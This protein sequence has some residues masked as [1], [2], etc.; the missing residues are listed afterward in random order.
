MISASGLS[1]Y[2]IHSEIGILFLPYHH[3]IP[4][5]AVE[6][7]KFALAIPILKNQTATDINV[8]GTAI[9]ARL[10]GATYIVRQSIQRYSHHL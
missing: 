5:I 1:P 6:H 10:Q 4:Q 8:T 2:I 9:P 3:K 7:S